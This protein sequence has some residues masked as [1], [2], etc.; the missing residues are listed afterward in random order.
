M[1][2]FKID[3]KIW[4]A[5]LNVFKQNALKVIMTKQTLTCRGLS[6]STNV[7]YMFYSKVMAQLFVFGYNTQNDVTCAASLVPRAVLGLGTRLMCSLHLKTRAATCLQSCQL[8]A[9]P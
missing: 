9:L 7:S 1:F 8:L 6:S 3:A 2:V 4:N 5:V